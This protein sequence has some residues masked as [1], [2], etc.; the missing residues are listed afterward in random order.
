MQLLVSVREAAEVAPALAG[1]ADVIDAKEPDLGSLGPVRGPVLRAIASRVPP[2]QAFSLAL[3]DAGR[4]EEVEPVIRALPLA[5]RPGPLFVKLG[6]AGVTSIR[7]IEELLGAAVH[8]LRGIPAAPVAVA[9]AYADAERAEAVPPETFPEL[10]RRAGA[11]GLL[12]DTYIK[13]GAS[14]LDWLSAERLAR[15]I[16]AARRA[17]LVTAVAGSLGPE[18]LA[19]VRVA[20]PDIV[21]V[22]GAACEGGRAGRVSAARVRELKRAL[23][24]SARESVGSR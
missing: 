3:G 8:A 15:W 19:A 23:G 13:D 2:G 14:L 16:A 7:R 1:G 4:P 18:Q 9:V 10:A 12:L 20:R 24:T 6:F 5:P 11:G 17:G 22:R 21:G